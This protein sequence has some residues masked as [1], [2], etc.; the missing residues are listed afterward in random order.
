[1]KTAGLDSLADFFEQNRAD[2][3]ARSE[4]S[5]SWRVTDVAF[6]SVARYLGWVELFV[7]KGL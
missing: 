5:K 7:P 6:D 3:G 2:G 1:M 4:T